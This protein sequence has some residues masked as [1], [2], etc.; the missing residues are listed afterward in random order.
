MAAARGLPV[1]EPQCPR[2]RIG[3]VCTYRRYE[4]GVLTKPLPRR[5]ILHAWLIDGVG[6]D[7]RPI[8]VVEDIETAKCYSVYVEHISFT[9][10]V[11][12]VGPRRLA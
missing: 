10:D 3:H 2:S 7:V 5:G 12:D 9:P 1:S 8:G 11:S 4:P 6:T